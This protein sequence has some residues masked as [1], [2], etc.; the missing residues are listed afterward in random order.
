LAES[1]DRKTFMEKQFNELKGNGS[2]FEAQRFPALT[3]T[4]VKTDP[5]FASWRSR[6]FNPS[7]EKKS[8]GTAANMLSHYEAIRQLSGSNLSTG[9]TMILEDDVVIAPHFQHLW[10]SLWPY[11]PDDWD[12]LRVGAFSTGR[13]CAQKV[14]EHLDRAEW[15]DPPPRHPGGESG[16]CKYCGTQALIVHPASVTRVLRRLEASRFMHTDTAFGANTPPNE[17]PL[18]APP[19]RVFMLRPFLAQHAEDVL[20]PSEESGLEPFPSVRDD[21]DE[22]EADTKVGAPDDDM[23]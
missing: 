16:P 5:R 15:S 19:L 20:E 10:N 22:R 1:Q 21:V 6:G 2:V 12:I 14:N 9:L 7:M 23:K 8:W 11:V 18:T 13:S 3:T 4:D 17:D